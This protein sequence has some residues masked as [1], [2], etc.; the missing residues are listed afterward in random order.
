MNKLEYGEGKYY[1]KDSPVHVLG[2]GRSFLV[3]PRVHC[4]VYD[5]LQV[6][7]PGALVLGRRLPIKFTAEKLNVFDK[8]PAYLSCRERFLLGMV[9]GSTTGPPSL[10]FPPKDRLYDRQLFEE[11]QYHE[12]STDSFIPTQG[13]AVLVSAARQSLEDVLE[14]DDQFVL[15]L[16]CADAHTVVSGSLFGIVKNALQAN[17]LVGVSFAHHTVGRLAHAVYHRLHGLGGNVSSELVAFEQVFD[18][19]K[20]PELKRLRQDEIASYGNPMHAGS[21]TI[22]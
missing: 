13:E 11:L 5:G 18:R 15:Q 10:R 6:M 7:Q 22:N 9:I 17:V 4:E 8:D 1:T 20:W 19:E 21:S 12:C 3:Y 16:F 2:M 14:H